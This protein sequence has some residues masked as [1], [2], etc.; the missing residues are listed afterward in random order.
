[1]T[2]TTGANQNQA[3]VKGQTTKGQD[4][5]VAKNS[6]TKTGT[7]N[8]K[9]NTDTGVASN[10]IDPVTGKELTST[11]GANQNQAGVKGQTTKGQDNAV[12]KNSNTKTGTENAQAN[13]DTGVASNTIDPATKAGQKSDTTANNKQNS[14][15]ALPVDHAIKHVPPPKRVT[16][17]PLKAEEVAGKNFYFY[18]SRADNHD[19]VEGEVDA[20]DFEKSRKMATYPANSPVKI[21]LPAGKTKQ[22]SFVCQVF[23]YRKLQKEY[24]PNNPSEDL[25]LDEKGNLVIPFELMRLQRGDIAI[26]YNV[27]FFKD[28]ALMRPESRYE[29]NNLLELLNENPSYKIMIHGHTNGN[30]AGKIIRMD[31]PGN[32]YS[33]TNTSQGMGSAKKLSEE[34][35]LIIREYLISSGVGSDRMQVKAWGGKKPIHDKHA[36]RANE[37]VRVE[38]EIL[39]D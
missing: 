12:A 7:E 30:A 13:K 33:L 14:L 20:I 2:S 18:L 3:G 37:N 32:F 16:M 22:I 21:L 24:D 25:Y 6:N 29:V 35:A 26:M 11:T 28:A 4:N 27:F 34:R 17:E 31:K 9:A 39:S 1:L 38:I 8:A 23:G 19:G 36:V 5:A 15:T 10:T